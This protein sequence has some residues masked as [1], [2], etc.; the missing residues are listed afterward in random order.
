M[1][2]QLC[3]T[4]SNWTLTDDSSHQHV[5]KLDERTFELIEMGLVNPEANLFEV[6]TDAV[7]LDDYQS[8]E[9]KNI[10]ATF[11]YRSVR[12]V[13][14]GYKEKANQVIA[15]CIFEY[16]GSF[17]VEPLSCDISEGEA[18]RLIDDYIGVLRLYTKEELL[19]ILK[20]NSATAPELFEIGEKY[21]KL[22]G[23]DPIWNYH[24]S[25]DLHEGGYIVPVKEGWLFIPY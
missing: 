17:S 14:R 20:E 23:Y 22:L 4:P 2:N 18:I 6:Y 12:E 13:Q 21:K 1:Q 11:G 10:L 7:C 19:H 9:I 15:E 8:D 25:D 16:F 24:L 5:R 3:K